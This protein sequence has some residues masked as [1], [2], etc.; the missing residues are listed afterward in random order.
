MAGEVQSQCIVFA[1]AG[2]GYFHFA[3]HRG[4]EGA[5]GTQTVDA[6]GV[7]ASVCR[8]PFLVVDDA[9]SN[10][11]HV[12]VRHHIG[13]YHH[14]AVLLVEG[15]DHD[16]ECIFVFVYVIAVQLHG[17]LAALGVVYPHIPAAADAEVGTF[18]DD[19]DDAFVILEFIDGLRSAV[20]GMVVDDDKIIFK[21]C[22]LH[23]YRFDGVTDG[24]DTVAYRN[25]DG[26]LIFEVT[27]RE[28]NLLEL[29]CQIPPD[30][31]QMFGTCLL[32]LNLAVTVFGVYIVENLFA[33][34]AG[35]VFHLAV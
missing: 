31:F 5:R 24:T 22:L 29:R 18:G 30:F 28:L 8:S 23:Q 7:V 4:I 16:G 26:G 27:G 10:H 35:I 32:H 3:Q 14:G 11:V 25:N 9:R 17:K 21:V 34:L 33:A 19:M 2:I 13:A 15:A 1:I 6:E 20:C 12:E